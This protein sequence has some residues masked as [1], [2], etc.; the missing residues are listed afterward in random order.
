MAISGS[1][2]S[3]GL[4]GAMRMLGKSGT[5]GVL[6]VSDGD[7]VARV[8]IHDGK[9][10][11]AT[12]N[13]SHP[14]GASFIAKGLLSQENLERVLLHQRRK[15]VK[16]PIGTILNEL[17]LVDRE[18]AASEIEEQILHV[19]QGV[20]RWKESAID[21][22]PVKGVPRGIVLPHCGDIEKL[23]LRVELLNAQ[24]DE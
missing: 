24:T 6:T 23:L 7:K 11:Y 4:P 2:G 12:S 16:Q 17:G 18:V 19:L 5:S 9:V 10:V 1:L 14:L 3:V 8:L 13:A 15:K 20:V 22:R 21:F